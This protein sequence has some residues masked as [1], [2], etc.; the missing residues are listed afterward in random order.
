MDVFPPNDFKKISYSK[1]GSILNNFPNIELS[2]ETIS[3]KKVLSPYNL[4]MAIPTGKKYFLW[5]YYSVENPKTGFLLELNKEKRIVSM[6]QFYP[7]NLIKNFYYGTIF[8]GVIV[9]EKTTPIFIIEDLLYYQGMPTKNMI[10]GKKLI[11]IKEFLDFYQNTQKIKCLLP[12]IYSPETDQENI[13]QKLPYPVHHFQQRC[14]D[15]ILPYI[16]IRKTGAFSGV[17]TPTQ[18]PSKYTPQNGNET[19]R[20]NWLKPQYQKPTIFLITANIQYDIYQLFAINHKQNIQE[21]I[22]Y[23]VACIPDLKTSIFMNEIFRTIKENVNLDYIEESDDESDFENTNPEKYV[24]LN[25]TAIISCLFHLKF[26]KWVPN[27]IIHIFDT[28]PPIQT[29]QYKPKIVNIMSL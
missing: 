22:Y 29:N 4:E 20:K 13:L 17:Q 18:P 21:Y 10:F 27:N 2:Y 16:N 6:F 28:F 8:Y 14:L 26:K 11:W 5:F 19:Y 12:F 25:R 15:K 9:F 1:M 23:D 24:D 7:S 3:H